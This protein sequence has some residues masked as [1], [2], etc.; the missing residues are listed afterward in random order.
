M[1]NEYPAPRDPEGKTPAAWTTVI[2]LL[3][4]FLLGTLGVVFN[5]IS[6]LYISIGIAIV[7]LIIGKIMAA[8][9]LGQYPRNSPE[10]TNE[11]S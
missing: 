4:A 1:S 7:G 11:T 5:H 6:I 10:A 9:G 3:F 8:M 2:I